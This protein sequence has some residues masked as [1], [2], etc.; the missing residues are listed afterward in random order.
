MMANIKLRS[1]QRAA[2]VVETV[3]VSPLLLFLILLTAEVT[4]AFVDHNTLTKS[5]RNAAR[6]VASNAAL[7]TTGVVLLTAT[8]V[9]ETQNLAAFGNTAGTGTPVLPGLA[10]GNVQVLDIGNNRVQ[11][12]ATYPYTGLLGGTLP[13]FGFGGDPSLVMNLQATVTMRAL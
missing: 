13:A 5:T 3:V 9:G 4:N 8:V 11:V 7:G 12:T 1:R 2:A 6:Y 10:P